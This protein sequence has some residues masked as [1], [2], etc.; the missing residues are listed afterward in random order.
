VAG[1]FDTLQVIPQSATQTIPLGQVTRGVGTEWE[2]PLI[3]RW[4]RRRAITVQASP[5]AGETFPS[6]Y[7]DVIDEIEA[8]E[9]PPGYD[10]FWD[11]EVDSTVDAQQSLQP[12]IIPTVVLMLT[13]IMLLYNSFRVLACIL[14]TVPFAAIGIVFGLWGLD[15]PMGFVAILG[16]LSLTGMMIKNMIVLTDAIKEGEAAGLHPFDACVQAA[17]TQ[18]R[19]I[20]LAAGTTVLG[21]IPLLPDPF[22]NAMAAAIMAGLTVG[23]TLTILLYPTLY[24]T[25]HGIRPPESSA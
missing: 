19:P 23:G 16:I 13:I 15:S 12:G 8:I 5:I 24:A 7:A 9:L 11:G 10:I 6:L 18:A 2:D 20:L 3:H 4:Q 14:L 21:V 17:V 22:W 25:L 1:G